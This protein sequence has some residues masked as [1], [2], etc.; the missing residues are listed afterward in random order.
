MA[1]SSHVDIV[2]LFVFVFATRRAKARL[3]SVLIV[4]GDVCLSFD[5][6]PRCNVGDPHSALRISVLAAGASM[7]KF[8]SVVIF[9]LIFWIRQWSN[10][11]WKVNDDKKEWRGYYILQTSPLLLKMT[12]ITLKYDH[13]T[14]K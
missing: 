11:K 6:N 5:C 13:E 8:S 12:I 14:I 1:P 7:M 4:L 10:V 3:M 2:H 9:E